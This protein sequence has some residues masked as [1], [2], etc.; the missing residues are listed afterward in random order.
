M[1]GIHAIHDYLL[2]VNQLDRTSKRIAAAASLLIMLDCVAFAQTS[3]YDNIRVAG[4]FT[5]WSPDDERM[6]LI[7]DHIWQRE[8]LIGDPYFEFKFTTANWQ[9]NWG[10]ANQS[11]VGLPQTGTGDYYGPNIRVANTTGQ[12]LFR[13]TFNDETKVYDLTALDYVPTNLQAAVYTDPSVPGSNSFVSIKGTLWP[14][15]HVYPVLAATAYY[16]VSP[17]NSFVQVPMWIGDHLF[18]LAE[19]AETNAVAASYALLPTALIPAQPPGTKVEYFLQVQA[20]DTNGAVFEDLFIPPEGSNSPN[21][22]IVAGGTEAERAISNYYHHAISATGMAKR[23]LLGRII[24]QATR[25]SYNSLPTHYPTTDAR[26]DGTI[27][28]L[29][30]DVQAGAPPYTY[31]FDAC[32][33]CGTYRI[34]GDCYNR[35]HTW[36]SSW[37]NRAYPLYADLHAVYPTDGKVNAYRSNYPFGEVTTPSIVSLN[38]CKVGRS[39]TPGYAGS[40]FEPPDF[41]K[42]DFARTYFYITTRYW[43]RD[44][45]WNSSDATIAAEMRPWHLDMMLRWH[46]ADPVS[47]KER[48]RNEAVSAIQGN[49]NPFIDNPDWVHQIWGYATDRS[50]PTLHIVRPTSVITQTASTATNTLLAGIVGPETQGNITWTNSTTGDG[51]TASLTGGTWRVDQMP[52]TTGVNLITVTASNQFGQ[53]VGR[54]LRIYRDSGAALDF[55]QASAWSNTPCARNWTDEFGRPSYRI[56]GFDLP[57]D[58]I[59]GAEVGRTRGLTMSGTGY[60]WSM[61]R[62]VVSAIRWETRRVVDRLSVYLAAYRRNDATDFTIRI[63]TNSG[64]S[65][66][67]LIA[68]NSLW[69]PAQQTYK[70]FAAT[71]LNL[72]PQPLHHTVIEITKLGGEMMFVDDL[73]IGVSIPVDDTDM[74]MVPDDWERAWFGDLATSDGL[75]DFDKDGYLDWEEFVA[76]TDP[77]DARS[78][79]RPKNTQTISTPDVMQ[80]SIDGPIPDRVYSLFSSTNLLDNNAWQ[81]Q[82]DQHTDQGNTNVIWQITNPPAKSYYRIGIRLP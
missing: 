49:R 37:F 23:V 43:G 71:N 34:E 26:P 24:D 4:T 13:F 78:T 42:G 51:G 64:R 69:F 65:Y 59:Q 18:L 70:R 82:G 54:S 8:I 47:E 58:P 3:N 10:A 32:N 45:G 72:T 5:G 28:D 56:D 30:S 73:D 39:A 25:L 53:T 46:E 63:S 19:Q 76:G 12:R 48:N 74:D 22:Y 80:I 50:Q 17:S 68:T 38:G 21:R 7:A 33:R 9:H 11:F 35:E 16:R 55:D 27:W 2:A 62:D 41:A 14:G 66:L 61:R 15:N 6:T 75:G 67:T 20:I 52:V 29:Y 60:A 77:T 57:V 44:P 1:L 81:H 40:V 36:P 31:T 79:H